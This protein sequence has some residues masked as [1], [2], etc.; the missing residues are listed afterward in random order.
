MFVVIELL[1]KE[2]PTWRQAGLL[3]VSGATTPLLSLW[4]PFFVSLRLFVLLCCIIV[5]YVNKVYSGWRR[6]SAIV[7]SVRGATLTPGML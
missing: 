2:N 5:T 6:G 3:V 1:R 4:Q 7:T